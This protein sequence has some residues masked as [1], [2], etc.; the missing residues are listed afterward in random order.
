MKRKAKLAK[1]NA[2]NKC[3][4]QHGAARWC[5]VRRNAAAQTKAYIRGAPTNWGDRYMYSEVLEMIGKP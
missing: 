5:R 4:C 1:D 2:T 3:K